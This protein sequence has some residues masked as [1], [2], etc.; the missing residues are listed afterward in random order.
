MCA[1]ASA[2]FIH[3]HGNGNNFALIHD[4][5][6]GGNSFGF[7]PGAI[8]IDLLPGQIFNDYGNGNGFGNGNGN[9]G[10]GDGSN[11]FGD[12]NNGFGNDFPGPDFGDGDGQQP[13]TIAIQLL[14]PR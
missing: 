14:Q 13:Q 5:G 8:P 3:D 7:G 9:N 2:G 1:Y 11:G 6:N 10:F 12:G 4:H